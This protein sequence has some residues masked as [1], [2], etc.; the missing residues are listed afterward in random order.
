MKTD[1]VYE[2]L[3]DWIK[4]DNVPK[5]DIDDLS[6]FKERL[7][8]TFGRRDKVLEY[9]MDS[10]DSGIWDFRNNIDVVVSKERKGTKLFNN[11]LRSREFPFKHIPFELVKKEDIWNKKVLIFDDGIHYGKTGI[12]LI[13][14][15][16][17]YNP[18]DIIFYS[19]ISDINTLK[20]LEKQFPLIKFIVSESVPVDDYTTSYNRLFYRIFDILPSPLDN[21]FQFNILIDTIYDPNSVISALL[22]HEK[23]KIYHVPTLE[24][25]ELDVIKGTILYELN[26]IDKEFDIGFK[27]EM[28]K[29][30][31]Y[32]YYLKG[33]GIQFT[34]TPVIQ[35]SDL[36]LDQCTNIPFKNKL[37]EIN[38][39][40]ENLCLDCFEINLTIS[41]FNI[42]IE[43]F[44]SVLEE[45][46]IHIAKIEK[47]WNL[48][49]KYGMEVNNN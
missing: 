1:K 8:N 44:L 26:C 48:T 36:D 2:W 47:R 22:H 16:L 31:F 27:L 46:K 37:C 39:K 25:E 43:K 38:E 33:K 4:S 24:K 15:L 19:V 13:N 41:L 12:D 14:T 32:I 7:D 49:E 5:L 11:Y 23:M 20:K 6:I 29:I 18:S 21:H 3:K 34:F 17:L 45:E 35:L 28:Y 40:N 42:F 30:R 10:I 9:I